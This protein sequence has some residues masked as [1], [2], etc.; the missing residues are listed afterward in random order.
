MDHRKNFILGAILKSYVETSEP[1]GSR[2][3]KRLYDM[4]VSA[5]TIRNEMSDLEHLGYLMKAHSSSG[6]IPSQ[7]AYRWYVDTILSRGLDQNVVPA[8]L[9][10]SL[11]SQSNE[12]ESVLDNACQ[13]LVE[14]T[15]CAALFVLPGRTEDKLM[16]IALIPLSD[17]EALFLAVYD[18][19]AIQ[20]ELIHFSSSYDM[21]RMERIGEIFQEI[22]VDHSVQEIY[23]L[24]SSHFF[25]QNF[26]KGNL[27]SEMVHFFRIELEKSMAAKVSYKGLTK[28]YQ[29]EAYGDITET[30][31]FIHDL[32]ND[33][34]L[35]NLLVKPSD[36]DLEVYIGGESAIDKLESSSIILAP[37]QLK[38]DLL[39]KIGILGPMNIPYHKLL[40]DVDRM[41]RYVNSIV[42]RN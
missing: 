11:L 7:Q 42:T 38:G 24:L 37:F 31:N 12:L 22:F 6:R 30:T 5:A 21:K 17:R 20:T 3:L 18:S 4:D 36:K 10:T 32:L 16:K 41:A 9:E 2:T 28:L 1:I 26:T 29:M 14:M 25:P 15:G 33:K 39:G 27:M 19:K 35:A 23:E 13:I 8:L 34:N 40:G